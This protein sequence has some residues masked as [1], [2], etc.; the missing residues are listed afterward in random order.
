MNNLIQTSASL[1]D[2]KALN[3]QFRTGKAYL[4]ERFSYQYSAVDLYSM[5]EFNLEFNLGIAFAFSVGSIV[6]NK[7]FYLM[8]L[9]SFIKGKFRE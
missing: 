6:V 2:P 8:P 3:C 7:L 9:P 4:I 1:Y 5:G